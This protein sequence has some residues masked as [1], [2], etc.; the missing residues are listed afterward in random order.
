MGQCTTSR[1]GRRVHHRCPG[2]RR[3][4]ACCRRGC[5]DDC[6][7]QQTGQVAAGCSLPIKSPNPPRFAGLR[8]STGTEGIAAVRPTVPLSWGGRTPD[9]RLNRVPGSF[10]ADLLDPESEVPR[11]LPDTKCGAAPVCR[12]C[13]LQRVL[14]H[15]CR[16]ERTPRGRRSTTDLSPERRPQCLGKV[17]LP[18]HIRPTRHDVVDVCDAVQGSRGTSTLG[19]NVSQERRRCLCR[20]GEPRKRGCRALTRGL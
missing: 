13:Q 8:T 10:G 2:R 17:Y 1:P 12:K 5:F 6:A 7:L 20:S 3:V 14:A 4:H 9:D 16:G 11:C 19:G 18:R 15:A